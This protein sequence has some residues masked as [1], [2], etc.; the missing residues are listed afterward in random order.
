MKPVVNIQGDIGES[1][2]SVISG[3]GYRFRLGFQGDLDRDVERLELWFKNDGRCYPYHLDDQLQAI[4]TKIM[5]ALPKIYS[6]SHQ[7]V[8]TDT[9]LVD[10]TNISFCDVNQML[11]RQ[12]LFYSQWTNMGQDSL[13]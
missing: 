10:M 3:S 2:P 4:L 1:R 12:P 11:D 5:Q 7:K 13:V 9:I 6:Y 8:L